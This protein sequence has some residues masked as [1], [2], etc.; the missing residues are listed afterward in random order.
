MWRL[1]TVVA[2]TAGT[3]TNAVAQQPEPATRE[4]AIEQEQ[5]E[6]AKNLH[7]YTESKTQ[8]VVNRLEQIMTNGDLKW[9]PF[10]YNAYSGGGFAAGLGYAHRVSSYNQ[11]DVR[12]S[13]SLKDYKRIEAE[14]IAP[15]LFERRGKL[16][17]LGGWRDATQVGFYGI[18]M[19]TSTDDRLNYRF[20]QPH[21]RK[22]RSK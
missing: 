8:E 20:R 17:L 7:P 11:I 10:F 13:Y 12:G 22:Q 19:N 5:A 4:A 9:H 1:L 16:S 2:L 3:A 14:F 21:A 18:G 6:K 15:R